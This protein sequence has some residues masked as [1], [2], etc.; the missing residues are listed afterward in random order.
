MF[1]A[2]KPW[3]SLED[4][5]ISLTLTYC[6]SSSLNRQLVIKQNCKRTNLSAPGNLIIHPMIAALPVENNKNERQM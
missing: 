3:G 2:S 6:C 4:I 5:A 1:S